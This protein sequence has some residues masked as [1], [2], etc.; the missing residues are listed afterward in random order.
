M[1]ERYSSVNGGKRGK[2]GI[3]LA[4][5]L[6]AMIGTAANAASNTTKPVDG[7]VLNVGLGTDASIIDPSITGNSITTRDRTRCAYRSPR[8]NWMRWRSGSIS[9]RTAMHSGSSPMVP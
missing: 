1:S 9:S 3:A 2:R 7:G 8:P 5:S 6:L 4:F